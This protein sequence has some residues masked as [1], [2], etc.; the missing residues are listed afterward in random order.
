MKLATARYPKGKI[1]TSTSILCY[2]LAIVIIVMVISQLMT[3]EKFLPIMQNYQLLGGTL[4]AK[5]VV[6]MLAT[7]GVFALPF[8]L[9]MSLSPLF[10]LCSAILLNI[11][12]L[13]WV[14]L[15]L[16]VMMTNPPLISTGLLGSLGKGIPEAVILPFS[17]ILLA[18]SFAATWLLRSDLRFKK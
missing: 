16:W 9:R 4:T 1:S 12:A 7:S 17:A 11:Y 14:K 2:G 13:I 5:I 10:R 8:L 6:F 3:I 18:A 15:G